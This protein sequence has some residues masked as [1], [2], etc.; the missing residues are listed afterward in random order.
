MHVVR[1]FGVGQLRPK[2]GGPPADLAAVVLRYGLSCTP[3]A[4]TVPQPSRGKPCRL[5]TLGCYTDVRFVGVCRPP[6]CVVL[7]ATM[8]PRISPRPMANYTRA[9]T[10]RQRHAFRCQVFELRA[11]LGRL[12][13]LRL[14]ALIYLVGVVAL[15]LRDRDTLAMRHLPCYMARV[16]RPRWIHGRLNTAHGGAAIVRRTI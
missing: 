5:A 13:S 4:R 15:D 6:L 10:C 9:S 3:L 7:S 8:A 14:G 1:G 12:P 16:I 11:P 2:S